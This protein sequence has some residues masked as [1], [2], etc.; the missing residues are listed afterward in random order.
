[1]EIRAVA[2]IGRQHQF[3]SNELT[4]DDFMHVDKYEFPPEGNS[5]PPNRTPPHSLAHTFKFKVNFASFCP[6]GTE[7]QH[8]TLQR[9]RLCPRR[10][11]ALTELRPQS[12]PKNPSHVWN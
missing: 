2:Q 6:A 10:W 12:I 3:E 8:P 4:M 11:L 9:N 5:K 1:V 7:L